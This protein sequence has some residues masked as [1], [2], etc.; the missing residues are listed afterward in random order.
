MKQ[1]KCYICGQPATSVEHAPA[2]CFFPSGYK[3]NLIT[4][5]SCKE[6]NEDTSKD[7]KYVR[8]IVAMSLSNNKVA[9][10]HFL[11]K[12]V[13]A[14][15]ESPALFKTT[16]NVTKQ[17]WTNES[18]KLEPTYA[19]QIDR[20][21]FDNVMRKIAYAVFFKDYKKSWNRELIVMTE[22]LITTDL[23][24]D[25]HGELI[26][27]SRPL[28]V[29][30]SFDGTNPSVFKYKFLPGVTDDNNDQLLRFVFYEG[31]EVWISA[32]PNS[33]GPKL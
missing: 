11:D 26:Q 17:V 5:D 6:H 24:P 27:S 18:G 23:Q 8:N 30:H 12:V 22:H 14:F 31:F 32:I 15:K 3:I 7:D 16:T 28:I 2:K 19:F 21:R 9:Y 1:K 29:E 25:K 4:V 13:T 20:K 10:D 33:K